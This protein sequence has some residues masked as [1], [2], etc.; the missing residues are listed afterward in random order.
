MIKG[1]DNWKLSNPRDREVVVAECEH[2]GGEIYLS[3]EYK[4]TNHGKVH[5]DCFE[6][7]AVDVLKAET[8]EGFEG[9]A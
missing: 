6:D 8:V 4:R 2:C 3:E 7:F 9:L 1:Y 5:E